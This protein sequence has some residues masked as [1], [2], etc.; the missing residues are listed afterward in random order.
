L[1]TSDQEGN[2]AGPALQKKSDHDDKNLASV[3]ATL[4]G[5]TREKQTWATLVGCLRRIASD[6]GLLHQ[7]QAIGGGEHTRA[8]AGSTS[9]H[10]A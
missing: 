4:F 3:L 2:H 8:S 1:N 6:A 9:T 5:D 10:N 7:R